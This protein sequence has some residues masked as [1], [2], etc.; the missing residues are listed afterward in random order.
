[1]IY[2]NICSHKLKNLQKEVD[3]LLNERKQTPDVKVAG[4][5]E[6]KETP[7]NKE[8]PLETGASN[9]DSIKHAEISVTS[10]VKNS[11]K[12]K[13]SSKTIS[14]S[15]DKASISS[16]GGVN[17]DNDRDKLEAKELGTTPFEPLP[18]YSL[19]DDLISLAN[20]SMSHFTLSSS[21]ESPSI[22]VSK[23]YANRKEM[24]SGE[25]DQDGCGQSKDKPKP[26]KKKVKN[27]SSFE[28]MLAAA[29]KNK[30]KRRKIKPALN[31]TLNNR[32]IPSI[33]GD[34]S[35]KDST[36]QTS[37]DIVDLTSDDLLSHTH[38][39]NTASSDV[40]NYETTST[41]MDETVLSIV[42]VESA[43]PNLSMAN[44]DFENIV[45]SEGIDSWQVF[46]KD[47]ATPTF[48]PPPN[49]SSL[50]N[51]TDLAQKVRA[52]RERNQKPPVKRK[53]IRSQKIAT[54]TIHTT[55]PS[56]SIIKKKEPEF[57]GMLALMKGWMNG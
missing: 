57:N 33:H 2:T 14:V 39:S 36:C 32:N 34:S 25:W 16:V 15:R 53:K 1:M 9:M 46:D 56:F 41:S 24:V 17:I 55:K 40:I 51:L 8:L 10:S 45:T 6:G 29:D 3:V 52:K 12:H 43:T 26:K 35:S 22:T 19:T 23:F 5:L 20:P 48:P 4:H 13:L 38:L 37:S 7:K 28:D 42:S 49:P 31:L 47:L 50:I 54:P 18:N 21:H 30:I 27:L 44:M 11:K